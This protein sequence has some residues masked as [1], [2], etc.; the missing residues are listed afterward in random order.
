MTQFIEDELVVCK[1]FPSSQTYMP[2]G[3]IGGYTTG[4][5]V[6]NGQR[7]LL[8]SEIEFLTQ[9]YVSRLGQNCGRDGTPP[10]PLAR[11]LCV[12]AGACPCTHLDD[13]L[14]MFPNVFFVLFDPRFAH[15]EFRWKQSHWDKKRVAVCANMFD[16]NTSHA[17]AEWV[18]GGKPR[19]WIQAKLQ[20]LD[21][22]QIEVGFDNLLF[23]S[24]I[25]RNAFD[26]KS[27]AHDMDAQQRWFRNLY[28]YAGILKFR[29]PFCN[30]EWYR[31]YAEHK[32]VRSYL[33]GKI[34]LPIWGPPSTTECRLYVVRGCGVKNYHPKEHET[35]MAGFESYDRKQQYI[36]AN[37]VFHSF[38]EA[39]EASVL[40][41]YRQCMQQYGYT[42]RLK[43][44]L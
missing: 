10:Q 20:S 15:E 11:F 22:N 1:D 36:V 28:A 26:E 37:R 29:L 31:E 7:K 32:G 30:N 27:I 24:D 41:M 23:I 5:N 14:K 18:S 34:Y 43:L 16:D 42:V 6:H 25:R 33:D 44:N 38:D 4:S 12:Y 8:L 21:I 39:A 40:H 19:H 17:I 2:Q 3:V 13:L 35:I 9:V